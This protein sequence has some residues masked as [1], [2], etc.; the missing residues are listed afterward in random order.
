M[1]GAPPRLTLG[2]FVAILLLHGAL[3]AASEA[4]R[5]YIRGRLVTVG[6]AAVALLHTQLAVRIVGG[7][8]VARGLALAELRLG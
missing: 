1:G 4:G 8:R 6:E 7:L 5:R 2:V 3:N